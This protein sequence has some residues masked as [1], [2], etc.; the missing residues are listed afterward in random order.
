MEPAV[1]DDA[2]WVSAY[3]RVSDKRLPRPLRIL[4]WQVLHAALQVGGQRVYAARSRQDLIGCCC[5]QPMCAPPQQQ[6][7]QQQMQQPQQ[8]QV[9]A[10]Q[11]QAQQQLQQAAP[12]VQQQVQQE[13]RGHQEHQPMQPAQQDQQL[14]PALQPY[15]Q[16]QLGAVATQV[17]QQGQQV[18]QVQQAQQQVMQEPQSPQALQAQQQQVQHEPQAQQQDQQVLQ[19]IQGQLEQLTRLPPEELAERDSLLALSAS[20]A[21]LGPG[22]QRRAGWRD[23]A[24]RLGAMY[25]R[26]RMRRLAREL[27]RLREQ[28]S[29]VSELVPPAERREWDDIL[30]TLDALSQQQADDV[31]LGSL[32]DVFRRLCELVARLAGQQSEAVP[33]G[34]QDA[35]RE[36]RELQV[37]LE[38]L[39][40]QHAQQ[41][42]Q[43]HQGQQAQQVQQVQQG[44]Q[45]QQAPQGQQPPQAPQGQQALQALHTQ[46]VQ[47]G[48]SAQLAQHARV[49]QQ[50]QQ[51]HQDQ[52]L[53]QAH[54]GQ[55]PEQ[56]QQGQRPQQPQHG[57]QPQ[58]AL[59][60]Q[61]A[62]QAQQDQLRQQAHH[63]QQ[64]QQAH[65]ERQAQQTLLDQQPQQAHPGQQ[66]QQ[67]RQGQYEL[68]SLSH[69]F[70]RC[71]SIRPAW[72]WFAGVWDRVQ[73]GSGVD[74]SDIRVVLLD[75]SSVFSP[76]RELQHLWTH[77]RLL[78][79]ES[80]WVV[81]CAAQGQ[82]YTA[83]Q[84][85]FRFVAALQQQLKQDWART[86][87]DIRVNS[88][89]PLSWLR[90]RNPTLPMEKFTAKWR[91][92]GVLYTVSDEGVLRVCLPL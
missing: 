41:D 92:A 3:R 32:Q 85:I 47:Q 64:P 42:Q 13:Q 5:R 45:P 50:A 26:G 53:R 38:G 90:G 1:A 75:D 20:L 89:V 84:V 25:D 58:Q 67:V 83:Q 61:Q 37:R 63:G 17:Q 80:I 86:Q 30:A 68:E 35:L 24:Q 52:Q 9:G 73:P 34:L 51:A 16:V 2:L 10:H 23:L 59:R 8:G 6:Q 46:Q 19:S 78:M 44:Q 4:G 27:R 70:V 21:M 36:L 69:L 66:S 33:E 49:V 77:L 56:A 22:E 29:S 48:Q 82:P 72:V 40:A 91:T 87:G 31:W 11:P 60:S 79:L 18:H 88:G 54:P 14:Q 81:R 28:G 57:Q 74:C 65:Q 76:P 15:Q 55:R 7:Q 12:Q 43:A 39:Q 62:Q 71:P